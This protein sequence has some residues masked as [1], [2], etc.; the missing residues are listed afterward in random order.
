MLSLIA[1]PDI[2]DKSALL[3]EIRH[4]IA[5]VDVVLLPGDM[6]HGNVENL[7]TILDLISTYN[8]QIYAVCGNM[9][10]V[11]MNMWLAREGISLHRKNVIVDEL[12]ILGCG[13]ALPF[14]GKYVFSE[15][16]LAGFLTDSV[17]GLPDAMP[18][19]L[20]SH[21]PPY[22]TMFDLP[23]DSDEHVGS[24]AVRAFIE[25]EQPLICFTGHMHHCVGIERLGNTQII[26]PGPIWQSNQYA[27]AEI[28]NG[29]VTTLEIRAVEALDLT[30]DHHSD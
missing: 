4:V 23:A 19:I 10:T 22:G 13:G 24:H 5:D 6:T 12:A 8:E 11:E 20:M 25:R 26:N 21:Q 27:Y 30:A 2:H 29:T 18:K 28:D 17:R 3:R 15:D 7:H 1:F 14:Y 9:D 16:E